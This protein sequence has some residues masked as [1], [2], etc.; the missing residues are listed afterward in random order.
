MPVTQL[1]SQ[2]A[3]PRRPFA[4]SIPVSVH[5][6]RPRQRPATSHGRS[7]VDIRHRICLGRFICLRHHSRAHTPG[8]TA[9]QMP[10]CIISASSV[11]LSTGEK[12][13]NSGV[14]QQR[15]RRAVRG[16]LTAGS[17]RMPGGKQAIDSESALPRKTRTSHLCPTVEKKTPCII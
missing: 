2:L 3:S 1:A 7:H 17:S 8:I 14:A 4:A 16:G 9:I 13:P 12:E 10:L 15:R 5:A 6:D 11:S